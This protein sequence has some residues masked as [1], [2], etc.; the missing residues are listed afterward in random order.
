MQ[1]SRKDPALPHLYKHALESIFVHLTLPELARVSVVCRDWSAAV[2][3]M[4][5]ISAYFVA[6]PRKDL[7]ALDSRLLVRHVSRIC[8]ENGN[9]LARLCGIIRQSTLLTKV[10]LNYKSIGSA[11]VTTLATAIKQSTS[12]AAIRLQGNSIGD[13]GAVALAD[14][15]KQSTSLTEIYLNDNLI[16]DVGIVAFAEAIKQSTT[17]KTVDLGSNN[18][19]DRGAFALVDA[20]KQSKSIANVYWYGNYSLDPTTKLALS[21]AIKSLASAWK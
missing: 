20:I 18:M 13:A 15:I 7:H 11:G 6:K 10:D 5:P 8:I 19:G 12:L 3:S 17:L 1:S 14:A 16:G 2:I 9:L 21:E 4:R